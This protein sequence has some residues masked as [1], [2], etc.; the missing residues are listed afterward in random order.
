MSFQRSAESWRAKLHLSKTRTPVLMGVTAL[1]V[2]V[3]V[4][5]GKMLLDAASSDGFALEGPVAESSSK[6][7][8]E[9]AGEEV[10]E[11]RMLWV[12]VGGAVAVSGVYEVSEGSRVLDVVEAAGGFAEGAA[13]DSLNLAREVADGE[14]VL[15]PSQADRAT[16]AAGETAAGS[17]VGGT[18]GSAGALAEG[19]RVNINTASVAQ[20]DTLP[21]VG[22]ST[23]EK[24]IADRE[25]N[26]P[27]K[28][29]EDL[30][31]VAGIGDKKFAA[32]ADAIS[33][34]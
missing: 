3:L 30:K 31:R 28:T 5:A 4:V 34:G 24:I 18:A 7:T 13:C 20:L 17:L 8:G 27:F 32:L 2:V 11:V 12:H 15:V 23:A 19:G 25:A 6:G 22:V 1:A 29:V 16:A 9:L 33:V 26:G 14:Q 21:G 10:S